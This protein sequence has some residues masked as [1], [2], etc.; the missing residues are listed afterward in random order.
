MTHVQPLPDRP[1]RLLLTS[2]GSLV[3]QNILDVLDHP[4][5]PRRHRVQVIG[6]NSI[7]QSAGNFRCDRCY[8]VPETAGPEFAAVLSELIHA[9]TPDI[10]LCGRD[11]D[12]VAVREIL[13]AHPDCGTVFPHGSVHSLRIALDKRLTWRFCQRHALP[14]AE[15]WVPEDDGQAGFDALAARFGYPLIAK[16]ARGFASKGVFYV[17]NAR[18]AEAVAA[19]GNYIFQEYLGDPAALAPYF[20]SLELAPPLFA[21]APGVFHHSAH[22]FVTGDGR[23]DEVFVS[24]NAHDAGV[25]VG[26]ERVDHPELDA[27]TRRFAQALAAEGGVGPMT[28]QYRQ[29]GDGAWKAMEINLR[30]NGNTLP[31]FLMGQDDLGDI[32]AAFLPGADFPRHVPKASGDLLATKHPQVR[33]LDRR[34]IAVL[35]E[36]REYRRGPA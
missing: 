15:T 17:R 22:C 29:S 20:A 12:T 28:V 27:L 1:V 23:T 10:V 13:D 24:R 25:T 9:E 21:H 31:R 4:D 5:W 3:G 34:D 2:V 32:F 18:Q 26:F 7:A 8:L 6:T 11:E 36:H 33:L 19:L 16:P 14:F 35:S 30:T